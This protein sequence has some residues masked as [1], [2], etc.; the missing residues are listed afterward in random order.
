MKPVV[1]AAMIPTQFMYPSQTHSSSPYGL[2]SKIVRQKEKKGETIDPTD[3]VAPAH[4]VGAHLLKG[5]SEAFV[6]KNVWDLDTWQKKSPVR[7]AFCVLFT[8]TMNLRLIA[9]CYCFHDSFRFPSFPVPPFS[10]LTSNNGH[11]QASLTPA[12]QQSH[13]CLLPCGCLEMESCL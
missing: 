4:P 1:S 5:G 13:G 7:Y 8:V 11:I 3:S 2:P 9:E 10:L 12:G 6:I